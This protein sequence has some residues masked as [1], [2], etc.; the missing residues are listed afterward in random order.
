MKGVHIMFKAFSI[1]KNNSLHKAEKVI[2]LWKWSLFQNPFKIISKSLLKPQS[3]LQH[4]DFFFVYGRYPMKTK[5]ARPFAQ[6][7]DSIIS[8]FWS[9]KHGD[10]TYGT[11]ET[12]YLLDYIMLIMPRNLLVTACI[13]I[14]PKQKF[15]EKKTRLGPSSERFL[16]MNQIWGGKNEISDDALLTLVGMHRPFN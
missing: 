10:Q 13:L 15:Q 14:C 7:I 12:N 1:A 6:Y 4:Y 16:K 8:L 11:F 5:Y 3:Y 2:A 9:W